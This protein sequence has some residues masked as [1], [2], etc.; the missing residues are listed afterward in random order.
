MN[1]S[2]RRIAILVSVFTLVLAAAAQADY[3]GGITFS[4]PVPSFMPHA[5]YVDVSIDYKVDEAGGGRV[6]ILPFT[7]GSPT[8]G[9]AV[10]GGPLVGPGT[11][12]VSLHFRVTTGSPVVDQLRVKLTSPDQSETWL[13]GFVPAYFAY[14]PSGVFNVVPDRSQDSALRYGQSVTI[15]FDY[16]TSDPAGCRIYARPYYHGAL[17]PGYS[18]SGSADL[19]QSGSSSQWFHFDADADISDIHFT[20]Y[21]HDSTVLLRQFDVPYALHWRAI[22]IYNIQFDQDYESS[23]HNTENIVATFTLDHTVAAGARVWTQCM[24]DGVY[25]PGSV[26]QGSGLEPVGAHAVSRYCRVQTG[27]QDVDAIRIH[28]EAGDLETTLMIPVRLH[29][30]PHAIQDITFVPASPAV[31]TNSERLNMAFSYRTDATAGVRIFAR[32]ALDYTPLVGITSA[33]SP[34]YSPPTGTGTFWYTFTSGDHVADSARFLMTN[35]DQSVTHL[36]FFKHGQWAWGSS[37]TITPVPEVEV[38]AAAQLGVVR[39]NPF[40]P[41]ATVPLDLAADASVRLAVYDVRGRLVRVLAD[42]PLAAGHHDLRFDGNGLAS[43]TYVCRLEGPGGVQT[44]RMT[45]VR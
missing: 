22:G 33:G 20:I 9:Y 29:Y 45:L 27:E 36:T 26:Y 12:S 31:L 19:P 34:L 14:G 44:Q 2:I 35:G 38:L 7:N 18:A 21:N 11:G 25:T 17:V 28:S 15:A 10:S 32:P 37:V 23:L 6:F 16:A 24:S 39:P 5:E 1:A 13:E 4:Q 40:N 30:G 43:G 42:G 41:V 3:L 8:P